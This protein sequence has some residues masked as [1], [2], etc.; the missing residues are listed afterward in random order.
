MWSKWDIHTFFRKDVVTACH[1]FKIYLFIASY[2]C[3]KYRHGVY[4]PCCHDNIMMGRNTANTLSLLCATALTLLCS[5]TFPLPRHDITNTA[6]KNSAV[7]VVA[8]CAATVPVIYHYSLPQSCRYCAVLVFDH[9]AI[10]LT[11]WRYTD[12][13]RVS[14]A[15]RI[16]YIKLAS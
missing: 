6:C 1:K 16:F 13:E 14:A 12:S 7:E 4:D 10:E 15:Y 5:F 2:F 9:S 8:L 11:L 3:D